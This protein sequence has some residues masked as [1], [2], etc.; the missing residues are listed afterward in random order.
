MIY[1]MILIG[2]ALALIACFIPDPTQCQRRVIG[3]FIVATVG[4][5]LFLERSSEAEKIKEAARVAQSGTFKTIPASGP[6]QVQIGK[7][8]TFYQMEGGTFILKHLLKHFPQLT[9]SKLTEENSLI[10]GTQAGR[11]TVSCLL[12]GR[13]G[14]T[15]ELIDN[16]WKVA[17]PPQT[18]DRN[19]TSSALEVMDEEGQV[20]LQL[21]LVGNGVRFQGRFRGSDGTR[22]GF[23]EAPDGIGSFIELPNV[24]QEFQVPISP[25]FLYP[26]TEHLGEFL[27]RKGRLS[28]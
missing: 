19:Y 23:V 15:V 17:P 1:L 4:I 20:V 22:I 25:I 9:R 10:V 8:G 2:G 7:S 6:A 18:W 14:R 24:E 27:P 11:L 28:E 5:Q 16:Q 26:S 3:A 12:R 21:E 13:N